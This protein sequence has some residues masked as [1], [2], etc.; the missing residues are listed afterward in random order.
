[1]AITRLRLRN[2]KSFADSG[3]MPLAPLTVVFGRNNTGKSSILQSLLLL[4]QTLDAPGY[5]ARLNL[6]GPAYAAGS[7]SDLV[8]RHLTKQQ[9]TIEVSV[10][11]DEGREFGKVELEFASDEPNSPRLTRLSVTGTSADVLE[12]RRG[13]GAGGPYELLIGGENL[14]REKAADFRFSVTDF[15]PNIGLGI[16]KVG[17]PRASHEK[18]RNASR[19]ALRLLRESLRSIRA[20]SAFRSE[21]ARRYEFNG[22]LP[23]SFASGGEDVV[24]ALIEDQTRR[25]R[26]G[27]LTKDVNRWL[28]AVGGVRLLPIRSISKAARIY[29]LR[30]KDESKS[31]QWANFADVGFGIGQ[32]LPVFV[33]GLRT[34]EGGLFLAQE[35]EIHLHPDAQLA[36]ADFLA[37]LVRNK[38]RVLVETHSENILL[39]IRHSVLGIGVRKN[40]TRRLTPRDVSIIHVDKDAGGA[41]HAKQLHLD[42]LGQIPDWPANFMGE[43]TRERM[44]IMEKMAEVAEGG[45]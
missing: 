8:H 27:E 18:S 26:P 28:K 32:A 12:I 38:R 39:R 10:A 34:A 3:E 40:G 44:D 29:E 5:G 36:M 35:P 41:S 11:T 14:G 1:V 16:P 33:E 25:R 24:N 4:R 45:N 2:F 15:L 13:V 37:A 17:R 20:V 42:E 6:G 9:V 22:R 7:F 30:L 23:G 19:H 43:A 21:P 31:R